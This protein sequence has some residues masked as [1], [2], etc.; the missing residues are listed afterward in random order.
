MAAGLAGWRVN[1]VEGVGAV[2]VARL[3]RFPANPGP[4]IRLSLSLCL[5]L[6]VYRSVGLS[7]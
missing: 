2:E 7:V 4:L 1:R 3:L 6:L 5:P